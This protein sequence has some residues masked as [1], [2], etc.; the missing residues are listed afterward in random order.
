MEEQNQNLILQIETLREKK[1]ELEKINAEQT[2]RLTN[3]NKA[4]LT[5]DQTTSVLQQLKSLEEK[6]DN[7]K[8]SKAFFKEQWGNAVKEIHRIKTENQRA[9]E[10][11]IKSNREELDSFK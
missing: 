3:F 9:L 4:S 7:A 8:K 5:E 10:V 6:L 2:E 1:F 11:Q